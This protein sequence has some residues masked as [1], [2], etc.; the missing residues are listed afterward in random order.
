VID[1]DRFREV[2]ETLR[3]NRLR[4][5]LTAIGVFWGV[6]LLIVMV[7]FGNGLEHGAKRGMSD[8][9][10]NSLFIWGER[11]SVPYAGLQPG[12]NIRLTLED[13]DALAM[14]EG[15]GVVAPRVSMGG[16]RGSQNVTREGKAGSFTV[17]GDTPSFWQVQPMEVRGRFI[18]QLD[19]QELRKVAVIGE[20]VVELLFQGVPDPVG[21][22]FQIRGVDFRVVGVFKTRAKG[23]RGA[24]EAATIYTPLT[25]FQKA[26]SHN[27]E[28]D[29]IAVLSAEGVRATAIEEDLV[30]RLRKRHRVA[31][32]DKQA[33]GSWNMDAEFQK[34]V[35]LFRGISLLV[36]VVGTATLM[37]GLVGVSNIMMVSVRER[38]REI[39]IRKAIGATPRAVIGQVVLESVAL[40]STSGYMGLVVGVGILELIGV[41]MAGT[42]NDKTMFDPPTITL[43]TAIAAAAMVALGGGLAG[44]FPAL[45]AA[46][47][48]TVTA[49]RDE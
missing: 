28:I 33:I 22:T 38:T 46:R 15:V 39:G 24:R 12:R 29:Y 23:D 6:F 44:L 9:A 19:M 32:D 27:E 13:A 26:L 16:R 14:A 45:Y 48:R 40:A 47:I 49:L 34:V 43:A 35:N 36:Y 10:T 21:E 42:P 4:T 31:P 18:N 41:F 30:A 1:F 8:S 5:A 11:S 3:R 7:G 37:A 2:L 25:T 20:R 17:M